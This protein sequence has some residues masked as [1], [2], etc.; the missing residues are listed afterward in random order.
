MSTI[1]DKLFL[2]LTTNLNKAEFP[3]EI[4]KNWKRLSGTAFFPGGD[5]VYKV[6]GDSKESFS[7]MILGQDYDNECN[8]CALYGTK[9]Q[10]E[11]ENKNSTWVTLLKILRDDKV[12]INPEDCFFTNAIMGFR[13]QNS[14]NT[15]I[16]KAFLKTNI[17][18]LGQNIKFFKYQLDIVKPKLIIGLGSQIPRFIGKCFSTDADL[19]VLS[20]I[21]SFRE[22]DM[23]DNF[24]Q[25]VKINY[26]DNLIYLVFITHPSLY[27]VN[28]KKR[29]KEGEVISEYDLLGK[30]LGNIGY[31]D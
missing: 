12:K 7:I 29:I 26:K 28:S 18:F 22:L 2:E 24:C 14:K 5:G 3:K 25:P 15:G 13:K 8:F 19:A 16:S 23:H 17:D 31:N 10:S 27:Y 4:V 30:A 1:S 9:H 6:N 21:K 20:K 11:V